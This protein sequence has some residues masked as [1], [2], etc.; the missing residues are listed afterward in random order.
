VPPGAGVL[1]GVAGVVVVLGADGAFGFP[2][3]VKA[4]PPSG[5]ASG[6][7]PAP[8]IIEAICN[9]LRR[10]SGFDLLKDSAWEDKLRWK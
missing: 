9:I 7:R 5:P 8:R 2:G 6:S 3:G 4:D 10:A 1:P